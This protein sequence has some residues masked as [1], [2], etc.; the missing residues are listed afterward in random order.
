MGMVFL[1]VGIA[2]LV[3]GYQTYESLGSQVE[4]VFT[5]S[6]SEKAIWLMGAGALCSALGAL[7]LLRRQ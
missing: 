1:I 6:P 3:W 2:L 7:F 5:G 4:E